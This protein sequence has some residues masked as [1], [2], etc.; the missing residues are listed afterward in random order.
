MQVIGNKLIVFKSLTNSISNQ[1]VKKHTL[2]YICLGGD[3]KNGDL[4]RLFNGNTLKY[5]LQ[6]H[7]PQ[8]CNEFGCSTK[9]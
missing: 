2:T 6:I 9:Q 4:H 5:H 8:M 3:L 1:N 7:K